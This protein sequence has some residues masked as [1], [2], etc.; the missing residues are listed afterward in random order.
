MSNQHKP[1][2]SVKIAEYLRS[3]YYS[4]GQERRI[5]GVTKVQKLLYIAYGYFL[6]KGR[7]L[8]DEQPQAWP[9]GPVFPRTRADIDY[10]VNSIT[11]DDDTVKGDKDVETFFTDLVGSETVEMTAAQLIVWA[12]RKGGAWHRTRNRGGRDFRWGDEIQD[13][14]IE[15]EFNKLV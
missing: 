12:H 15:T 7:V 1:Y 6:T 5:L 8:L 2:D 3:L 11:T 4:K 14:D 9:Y 13:K 10:E